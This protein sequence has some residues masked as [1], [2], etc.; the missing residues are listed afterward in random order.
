M[1][2]RVAIIYLCHGNLR[3]LPEVVSSFAHLDYPRDRLAII[4]IPNDSPDGI[5]EVIG[6]EVLPRS[7]GDLPEVVLIDDGMNR[8][9][10][11]GNNL[12]IRWALEHGFDYVFLNNGDL[13]LHQSAITELVRQAQTDERIGS[14]QSLVFYWD[15]HEKINVSGGLLHIAGYG[16]ARNNNENIGEVSL[17]DGEDI[18]YASG[19]AV[20]YRTDALKHVGML[21]EGFFM[22]HEDLEL[23]LRLR[24]AGFRNVLATRSWAYHDYGFKRNP[25]KFAW[26]ELYRWIV[27]LSYYKARTLILIS[28][29]LLVIELGTWAMALKGGWLSAKFW[30]YGQLFKPSNQQLLIKMRR[31]AQRLRTIKDRHLLQFVTGRIEGQETSNFVV[32]KLANPILDRTVRLIRKIIFW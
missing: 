2:P 32:E 8:G 23:G 27:V 7:A 22:Y 11:G 5:A 15:D 31:R 9:F 14:V 16:Y 18:T 13:K 26:M 29:V 4:M 30:A 21:E 24:I 10:A 17:K 20:L 6:R 25:K 3:H 1:K 19:A 12:G 28:P